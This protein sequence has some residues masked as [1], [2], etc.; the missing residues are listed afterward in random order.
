[1]LEYTLREFRDLK[2]RPA[3]EEELRRA[4]NHLKGSLMLNLESPGSRMANLAR[5]EMYHGRFRFLD[6][7]C[8]QV[9]DVT[10]EQVHALSNEWFNQ[11]RI[12]LSVLG[13]LGETRIEREQLAC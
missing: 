1:M 9:E 12:A 2:E 6:E 10:A 11:E 8:E 13:N 7:I 4:K 5:Q 3:E